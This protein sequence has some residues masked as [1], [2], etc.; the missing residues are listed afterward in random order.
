MEDLVFRGRDAMEKIGTIPQN[1]AERRE[2]EAFAQLLHLKDVVR[3]SAQGKHAAAVQ[4]LSEMQFVPLEVHRVEKCAADIA[5]LHP[6]SLNRPAVPLLKRQNGTMH[7]V[8]TVVCALPFARW[9]LTGFHSFC[10]HLPDLCASSMKPADST[11][12]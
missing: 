5:S 3:L 2:A 8:V 11:L 12:T 9:W 7:L 1:A 10:W 6:V 4:K